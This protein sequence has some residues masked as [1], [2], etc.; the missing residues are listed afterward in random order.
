MSKKNITSKNK[1]RTFW[2]EHKY[3]VLPLILVAFVG[4]GLAW[5]YRHQIN[6]DGVSYIV[7]AQDYASM[8]I[9]EAVNGYWSPLLSWLLVPFLWL[10]IDPQFAFRLLSF[11]VA[12]LATTI[13]ALYTYWESN[14][15]LRIQAA[16]VIAV[17]FTIM[18]WAAEVITP[19]LLSGFVA[20]LVVLQAIRTLNRPSLLNGALLGLSLSSLY[21][22]KSIGFYFSIILILCLI[23]YAVHKK[24]VKLGRPLMLVVLV[25][26]LLCGTW[27]V[28]I[29]LKYGHITMSTASN[30]NFALIGPTA[31]AIPTTKPGYLPTHYIDDI[32]AWDDPSFLHVRQW[33]PLDNSANFA[34]YL[35]HIFSTLLSTLTYFF[36]LSSLVILALAGGCVG[37]LKQKGRTISLLVLGLTLLTIAAYSMVLIEQ[38][39]LWLV[40]VPLLLLPALIDYKDDDHH[41]LTS[42]VIVCLIMSVSVTFQAA[43]SRG[44]QASIDG[45]TKATATVMRERIAHHLRL[46]T[47]PT[48]RTFAACYYLDARCQGKFVF[49]SS[50]ISQDKLTL[51]RLQKLKIDH[52]LAVNGSIEA[53]RKTSPFLES[54]LRPELHIQDRK[55][56]FQHQSCGAEIYLYKLSPS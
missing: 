56:C 15:P 44:N 1:I 10:G 8:H 45:A 54:A 14:W 4:I 53:L 28:A 46:A 13:I 38:R 37:I 25:F 11:G 31:P 34:Y 19:D 22:V 27:I 23:I 17:G 55:I 21:F 51:E 30:Y 50:N 36:M 42:L 52:Y 2:S 3:I 5:L 7:I 18:L 24:V 40:A 20:L 43:D 29:S 16:F 47:A 6:P 35:R 39:Y 26:V 32:D 41:L 12:L 49:S 33:S 9:R 48:G